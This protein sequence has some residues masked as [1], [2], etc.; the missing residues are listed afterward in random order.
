MSQQRGGDQLRTALAWGGLALVLYLVYLVV[1]PFLIPLAWGAVL[2]IVFYPVHSALERR[3]SPGKAA[4]VSTLAATLILIV[5]TLLVM[6][7]FIREAL[8]A[9]E[10]VQ[11]AF[12]EGR[13]ASV[14][15]LWTSLE[16]RVALARGVDL[17]ALAADAMQRVGAFAVAQS[18]SLLRGAATSLFDLGL[19]LFATFF[20]LRDS[21]TVLRAIRRLL[22]MEEADR[23]QLIRR[24][25][26]LVSV[27]VVSAVIVA[28]VQG[29]L[30]GLAFA[31]VGI[32]APV[33]WGVIMAF[34]CLLP[35]GAWV[36]WLPAALLLAL[37]GEMTRALI[38]VALGAAIVSAADNVLRPM[39]L[40]G[41]TKMNGLV[42]FVSLLGGLSVFGLLGVVLG[43]IV[44]ATALGLLTG[45]LDAIER[46][47]R[48]L[49]AEGSKAI[50]AEA[51]DSVSAA[52]S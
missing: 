47:E 36:I 45:Y 20:L 4:A 41:R 48:G 2:A 15:R 7:A 32:G 46:M 22:P 24:T 40:S 33:F 43:P 26:D 17:A 13:L 50:R 52:R 8:S 23:E 29:L 42:I 18:G 37:G 39:L 1:R 21:P 34:F 14:E 28:A 31:A 49:A 35:F 30:G 25:R 11:H 9:G 38:L 3:M 51:S 12:A 10:G 16:S 6:T 19:A 27:G 5:P 44:V